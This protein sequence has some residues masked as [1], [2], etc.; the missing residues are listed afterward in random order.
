MLPKCPS[1]VACIDP[2]KRSGTR[3]SNLFARSVAARGVQ[4][5]NGLHR[6][7]QQMR[8]STANQRAF[9]EV[10]TSH[11]GSVGNT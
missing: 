3:V 11:E 7:L 2:V 9:Y 6:L 4:R 8:T 10:K 5:T 1:P